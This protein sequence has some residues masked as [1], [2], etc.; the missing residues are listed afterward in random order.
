MIKDIKTEEVDL[1]IGILINK[2]NRDSLK[3][4]IQ[5]FKH[6]LLRNLRAS[7]FDTLEVN[8]FLFIKC[9]FPFKLVLN[10]EQRKNVVNKVEQI[11]QRYC[12]TEGKLYAK[13]IQQNIEIKDITKILLELLKFSK[14]ENI[15]EISKDI[16]IIANEIDDRVVRHV[17]NVIMNSFIAVWDFPSN[18]PDIIML[19]DLILKREISDKKAG[20]SLRSISEDLM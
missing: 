2:L 6:Y 13:K 10:Q 4:L 9:S 3:S 12:G 5:K 20:V 8:T 17:S 7:S 15:D 19:P 1:T 14:T 16:E 11:L 18:F